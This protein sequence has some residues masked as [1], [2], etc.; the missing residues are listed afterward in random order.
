MVVGVVVQVQWVAQELLL[1]EQVVQER[2]IVIQAL[3]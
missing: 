3:L 2:L 1:V